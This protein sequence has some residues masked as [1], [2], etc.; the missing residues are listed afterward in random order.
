MQNIT[1]QLI[2]NFCRRIELKKD[3]SIIL[4]HRNRYGTL[5]SMCFTLVIFTIPSKRLIEALYILSMQVLDICIFA[6]RIVWNRSFEY[7]P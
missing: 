7:R 5:K 3:R 4:A 2:L 1:I 6:S